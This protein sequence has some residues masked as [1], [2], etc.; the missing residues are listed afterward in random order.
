[1]DHAGRT[2]VSLGCL[3]LL[4]MLVDAHEH[5]DEPTS[6]RELRMRGLQYEADRIGLSCAVV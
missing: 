2:L 4:E 5:M 6:V 3:S 1:M